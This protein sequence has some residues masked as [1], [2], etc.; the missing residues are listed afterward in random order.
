MLQKFQKEPQLPK[1]TWTSTFKT[2]RSST[3]KTTLSVG[4]AENSHGP[5]T[6]GTLSVNVVISHLEIRYQKHPKELRDFRSVP[7]HEDE[8]S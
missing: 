1:F 4:A 7:I 6:V 8:I 5:E 3:E 2:V